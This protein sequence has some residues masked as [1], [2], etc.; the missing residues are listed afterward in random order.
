MKHTLSFSLAALG[1]A[2]IAVLA[3][4]SFALGPIPFSLQNLAIGLIASLFFRREGLL[5]I[6]LYLLLGALGLPVFSGGRG[7]LAILL[8]PTAG[9]LWAYLAYGW[10]VSS[11]IGPQSSRRQIFWVNSLGDLLVLSMGSL[12]LH[13]LANLPLSKAFQAGF[14]PFILGDL[15]K[16]IL[17]AGIC[18]KIFQVLSQHPYFQNL[19]KGRK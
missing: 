14:L 8:G 5:A 18:P 2:A 15:L 7:G 13:F 19:P 3:Q 1:A 11:L 9:Y 12:G 6:S 10:L 17:I 4:F 16:I